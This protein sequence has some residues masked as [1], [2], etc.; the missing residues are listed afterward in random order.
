M[1]SGG[2]L[3]REWK[4]REWPHEW[5]HVTPAYTSTYDIAPPTGRAP[6]RCEAIAAG[7]L[8]SAA[9]TTWSHAAVGAPWVFFGGVVEELSE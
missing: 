3:L 7:G 8:I 1:L 5:P 6:T 9:V 2:L 4:R